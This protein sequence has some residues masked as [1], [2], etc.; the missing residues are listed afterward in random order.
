[1][2]RL[3]AGVSLHNRGDL[4]RRGS[5]VLH[6][7]EAQTALQS[8]G[9]LGLHIDQL[10]LNELIR[11]ERPAE[12]LSIKHVLPRRVPTTFSGAERAPGNA[13]ACGIEAGEWPL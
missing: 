10:F 9:N 3:A 7:T 12:L 11:G 6:P 1:I 4:H 5:V 8:Q 13:V 2:Q